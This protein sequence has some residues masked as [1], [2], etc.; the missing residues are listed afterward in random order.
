MRQP[1][2]RLGRAQC[3]LTP[4]W[5]CCCCTGPRP[6][7]L[8]LFARFQGRCMWMTR[9]VSC[10]VC[11]HRLEHSCAFPLGQAPTDHCVCTTYIHIQRC[12]QRLREVWRVVAGTG[13]VHRTQSISLD[14]NA[15]TCRVAVHAC[16][17]GGVVRHVMKVLL[18]GSAGAW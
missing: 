11:S 13:F 17:N 10:T 1:S 6:C 12:S 9:I 7:K 4:V 18:K 15:T 3:G 5:R 8:V 2:V 16:E 14:P